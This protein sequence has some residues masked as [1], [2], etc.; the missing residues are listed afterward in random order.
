MSCL[1]PTRLGYMH[2]SELVLVRISQLVGFGD[3][4]IGLC[5]ATEGVESNTFASSCIGIIWI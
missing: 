2:C 3:G 5:S 1:G 4:Y